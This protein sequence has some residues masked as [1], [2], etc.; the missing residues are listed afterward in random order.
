MIYS[1]GILLL[2]LPCWLVVLTALNVLVLGCQVGPPQTGRGGCLINGVEVPL[3]LYNCSSTSLRNVIP[4]LKAVLLIVFRIKGGIA[5]LQAARR[6]RGNDRGSQGLGLL[7]RG[8]TAREVWRHEDASRVV[9]LPQ[10]VF[11]DSL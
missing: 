1:I 10:G 8:S 11:G 3:L 5:T 7:G 9:G 2:L 6:L 4:P